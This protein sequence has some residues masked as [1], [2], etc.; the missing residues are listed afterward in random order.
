MAGAEHTLLSNEQWQVIETILPAGADRA[1]FRCD[2]DRIK[3][4]WPP[5]QRAEECANRARQCDSFRRLLPNLELIDN[6][7]MLAE[8][9]ARQSRALNEQASFFRRV[10]EES[11]NRPK[12][13]QQ[14]AAL[15]LWEQNGGDLAIVTP[16]KLQPVAEW[17][18]QW[19]DPHGPVID[20]LRA[21]SMP[22]FGNEEPLRPDTCKKI[23]QDYRALHFSAATMAATIKTTPKEEGFYI[24]HNGRV[25][26][27][28]GND[29][30]PAILASPPDEL[31]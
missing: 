1:R 19:R 30:G 22:V 2:L 6:R 23:V 27:K 25:I 7:P 28:D 24:I 5:L 20:F 16:K 8:Q 13:S 18:A 3:H 17:P 11:Q 9:L 26:D 14:C 4:D 31:A 21:V 15:W 29:L 10:H 12:F